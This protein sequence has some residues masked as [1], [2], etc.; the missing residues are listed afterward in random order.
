MSLP[1]KIITLEEHWVSNHIRSYYKTKGLP[2]PN[3]ENGIVGTMTP[4]LQEWGPQRLKNLDDNNIT[5]QIVSHVSNT[6]PID[7]KTCSAANDDMAAQISKNPKGRYKGF[8]ILP[9]NEPEAAANELRRCIQDLN[10]VGALIDDTTGGRFYDAK[11][12]WPVF[13][14]AQDLDVP[15]YIHPS[16]NNVT[17]PLLYDGNYPEAIATALSQFGWGWHSSCAVNFLRMFSAGVFDAYPKLKIVLGHMGEMLP[18]Q[19]DRIESITTRVYPAVGVQ[20]G[21]GLRRVWDENVWV[22]TSGMFS[23]A[24]MACLVRQTEIE[25]IMLS[26]DFPFT[27]NELGLKFL[28]QL[29][30]DG[31]VAEEELEGIAWRNAERL[32]RL[33]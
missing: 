6:I 15:I 20:L 22:T 19:F 8:A 2:D 12:F 11:F 1:S 24:P 17:K 13:R 7:S 21:R 26:V 30:E 33:E 10:F 31:M 4:A 14:E 25:R 5:T 27:R 16:P 29:Q 23:L 9:M 32:L 18:F 3:D 28:R